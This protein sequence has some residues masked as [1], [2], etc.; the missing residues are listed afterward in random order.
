MSATVPSTNI[1][2]F[3]IKD[4]MTKVESKRQ[5]IQLKDGNATSNL[6]LVILRT[7]QW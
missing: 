5:K 1:G 7:F 4:A 3:D 2:V 6:N